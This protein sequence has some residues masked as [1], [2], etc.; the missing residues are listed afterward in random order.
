[1]DIGAGESK[2]QNNAL[3]PAIAAWHHGAA[4]AG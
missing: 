2:P 3:N 1:V 4:L